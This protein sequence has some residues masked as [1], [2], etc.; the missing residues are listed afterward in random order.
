MNEKEK[1]RRSLERV[2]LNLPALH[3]LRLGFVSSAVV[4][5]RRNGEKGSGPA[6]RGS[7]VIVCAEVFM[8]SPTTFSHR[9]RTPPA[10]TS[11]DD[12]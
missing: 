6:G 1:V 2:E 8:R 3:P 12:L 11:S 5:A 4:A 7:S 9:S 10:A